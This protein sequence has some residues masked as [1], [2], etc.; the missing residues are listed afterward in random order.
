MPILSAARSY[1]LPT[2]VT[3]STW[4]DFGLFLGLAVVC[5]LVSALLARVRVGSLP[6]NPLL[7][8]S[9]V[10][11]QARLDPQPEQP[12]GM[13]FYRPYLLFWVASLCCLGAALLELIALLY[14]LAAG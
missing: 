11:T 4:G 12:P 6:V 1:P 9:W 3:R 5:L 7:W 8:H 10:I 2:L 14:I 13:R